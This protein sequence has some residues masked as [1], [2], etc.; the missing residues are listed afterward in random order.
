MKEDDRKRREGTA[1]M[2]KYGLVSKHIPIQYVSI[3]SHN[4]MVMVRGSA[5]GERACVYVYVVQRG[6]T[7]S[8]RE[9]RT[10]SYAPLEV[11]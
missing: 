4:S 3:H 9:I 8:K 11:G 6:T 7:N 5:D 2:L 10:C 1:G